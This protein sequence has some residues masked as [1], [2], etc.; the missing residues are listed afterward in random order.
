MAGVILDASGDLFG[1]TSAGGASGDGTLFEI[2]SGSN[3]ITTLASFNGSNG[4][5]PQADLTRDSNGNLFGTAFSGGANNFGTVFEL[6]V[7]G[8]AITTLASF[9]GS[10]GVN[11]M[12]CRSF[13]IQAAI[14]LGDFG[15]WRCR[16]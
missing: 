15:G 3:A 6:P 1:T 2:V 11:P 9:N 13:L 16:R 14:S 4:A 8:D 10:N 12:A 5:S 7:G